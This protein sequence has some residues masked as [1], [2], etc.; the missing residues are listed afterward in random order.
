VASTEPYW[1]K[2]R[3]RVSSLQHTQ[4]Q[5][6]QQRSEYGWTRAE[7]R[8]AQV[9]PQCCCEG[10]TTWKHWICQ[11]AAAACRDLGLCRAAG[12][13]CCWCHMLPRRMHDCCSIGQCV[14]Y[15]RHQGNYKYATG[16]HPRA[17][18]PA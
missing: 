8:V 18:A 16:M 2:C 1:L 17:Q 3:R 12:E 10:C 9:H 11:A 14:V 13:A 6:Q 5:Q 7:N 4:R 15:P